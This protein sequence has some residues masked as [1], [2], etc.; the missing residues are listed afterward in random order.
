M[1]ALLP[2]LLY[3]TTASCSFDLLCQTNFM[4]G[5]YIGMYL[6]KHSEPK[7]GNLYKKNSGSKM[8]HFANNDKDNLGGGRLFLKRRINF[9]HSL[10]V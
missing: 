7:C 1:V 8:F 4:Q 3:F 6:R 10:L 9:D 5:Y 2:L